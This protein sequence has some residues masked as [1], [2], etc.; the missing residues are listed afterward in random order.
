ME[1]SCRPVFDFPDSSIQI[2]DTH[3]LYT[4]GK[5]EPRVFLGLTMSVNVQTKHQAEKEC[6]GSV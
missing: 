6:N 5:P 1:A 3:N 2:L 4:G